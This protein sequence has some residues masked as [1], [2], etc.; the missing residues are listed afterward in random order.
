MRSSA[1]SVEIK[2]ALK[3][4]VFILKEEEL[5]EFVWITLGFICEDLEPLHD[6]LFEFQELKQHAFVI[7]KSRDILLFLES[8]SELKKCLKFKHEKSIIH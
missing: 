1:V 8:I 5:F 3:K 6:R 4:E 7:V 2:L